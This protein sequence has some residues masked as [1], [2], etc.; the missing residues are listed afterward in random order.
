MLK[1]SELIHESTARVTSRDGQGYRALVVGEQQAGG[2]WHG[3][4]EFHPLQG[5]R[6][7]S[8][9]RE[10]SQVSRGALEYW[11]TGLEP[12]YYEGAFDRAV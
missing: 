4:I 9:G 12:I 10:T 3:R 11:A 5:G 6:V 8:T 7:R 2:G 1:S